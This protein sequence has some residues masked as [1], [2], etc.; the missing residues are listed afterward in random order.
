MPVVTQTTER[1]GRAAGGEGVG[2][3]GVGDRDPRLGH[4]GQRAE[5]VD[6]AVQLGRLLRGDLA[7][8]HGAHRDLVGEPP[9][10]EGDA[11]AGEADQDA[12][13]GL[14]TA[15]ISPTMTATKSATEQEHDGGHPDGQSGVGE[16]AGTGHVG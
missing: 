16:E 5:P 14:R 13:P 6:H 11:E 4:V 3:S 10:E 1:F 2:Q 9:L 12:K 8:P 7:G 15:Y